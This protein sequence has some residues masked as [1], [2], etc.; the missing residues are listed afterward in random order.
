MSRKKLLFDTYV[1]TL[2]E[3]T[4]QRLIS[5][6]C[7]VD[8]D[9]LHIG[10]SSYDLVDYKKVVLLGSGKAVVPMAK[11]VQKLLG[12]KI[13][14][15][16]LVGPYPYTSNDFQTRYIQSSHPLPSDA[17]LEAADALKKSLLDLTEDDLFIYLLSGGT[18]SL[19]EH[20]QMGITLDDFQTAT[21][22]MLKSGMPIEM[23]NSVRKHLSAVKG[24]RLAAHTKAQGIVL[25]LSDVI[26]DD[27]HSIGSAPLY[28]DT[29]TFTDALEY[30]KEYEA[31]HKLPESVQTY[32][33]EG[34]KGKHRET[35]KA[36]NKKVTHHIV[37]SNSEV[38]KIAE[39]YLKTHGIVT[40]KVDEP[41]Q[42]D[43]DNAVDMLLKLL[44][45]KQE[46]T[47]CYILGG[48][49]TVK[50]TKDGHGGRNQHLAL[51]FLC[52]LDGDKEVTLLCAA[53][54]GIDG[55][56]DA[57]G[58][59]IDSHSRVQAMNC[60]LDPEHYLR[61]FDSNTFFAATDELLMPGPTH[62]NLLDIVLMLVENPKHR[63]NN[64]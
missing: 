12:D 4:P 23:L 17:S 57:A 51:A 14:Q 27:L 44:K 39:Q 7:R 21:S 53:T 60:H 42:G 19:V 25:T 43:T 36:P 50:V 15:T 28:C 34:A 31:L 48:E 1:H 26:S 20:P 6:Q 59:L 24:G 56:S 40:H 3:I 22:I 30:L 46:Q 41:L 10:K 33:L 18:S 35:P 11:A 55:N 61:E 58:A 13:A 16:L 62:N 64:G 5:K 29:S 45:E 54:D 52:K 49:S 9:M 63:S 47:Y 2:E 38:M 8:K 32:L 37:G